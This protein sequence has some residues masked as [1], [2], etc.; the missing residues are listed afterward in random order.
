MADENELHQL[1]KETTEMAAQG[2]VPQEAETVLEQLQKAVEEHELILQRQ[3][4]LIERLR[5]ELKGVRR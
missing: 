5:R 2:D 3:G 4:A 1:L